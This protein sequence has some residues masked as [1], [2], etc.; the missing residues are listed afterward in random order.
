MPEFSIHVFVFRS[1]IL[2]T[3]LVDEKKVQL[4]KEKLIILVLIF[5]RKVFFKGE[6]VVLLLGYDRLWL[7]GFWCYCSFFY[8]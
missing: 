6:K 3:F 1:N 2:A 4:M 5:E 7:A 8:Y